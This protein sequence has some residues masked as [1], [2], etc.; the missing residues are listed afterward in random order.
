MARTNARAK[1]TPIYTHEGAKA[2]LHIGGEAQ[3]RRLVMSCMLWEK[4]F[5]VDGKTIATQIEQA[6]EK[7]SLET[8]AKVAID[9]RH[10]MNLRHVPLL[11]LEI[12]S[13]RGAGNPIVSET[14]AAVITRA[15]EPAELLS[16]LW[17]NG[18]KMIPAGMRKGL[19]K[20]FPKFQEYHLA[21]YDRE[22][23]VKLRDV[24]RLVR[25]KPSSPEQASLWKRAL[26]GELAIP[27]T[28]ETRLSSGED[29]KDVWT[30]MLTEGTLGYL[31]LLRN[32]RN[33]LSVGVDVKLIQKAILERKGSQRV[34]PF[35]YVAAARAAPQLEKYIDLALSECIDE[36][37]QLKGKTAILVD[38]SGSMEH[39]LSAKSDLTRMD[40]ACALASLISCSEL[41]VFSFSNGVREVPARRGM[42]GIDVIQSSQSHA[43]THLGGAIEALNQQVGYERLIVITDEQAQGSVPLPLKGTKAYVINVASNKNGIL[44]GPAWTH[45]DG[46]SEGVIKYILELEKEG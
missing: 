44:Y 19:Q 42:A 25:P 32:L 27:D 22:N 9:A 15:D 20:A 43:G 11:L 26:K 30:S 28:W 31:A 45:I 40:A 12:L 5:Y 2:A 7:V 18:R 16:V 35:R 39:K 37:V 36:S 13:K 24:L 33:M 46:F 8:L 41:R 14:V 4:E 38:V 21:K 34:L 29:K 23:A 3:L 6:A 1:T 17:R 10:V